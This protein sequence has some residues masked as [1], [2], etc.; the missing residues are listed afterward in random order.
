[1]KCVFLNKYVNAG[2][3]VIGF[4]SVSVT[5]RLR[6]FPS[7]G[8][9]ISASVASHGVTSYPDPH[10]GSAKGDNSAVPYQVIKPFDFHKPW[11]IIE[12]DDLYVHF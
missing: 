1:M 2:N 6:F 8:P 11:S 10:A 3:V 9:G 12:I 4:Q 7:I 5:R